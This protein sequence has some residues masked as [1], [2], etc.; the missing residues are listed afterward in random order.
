MDPIT[1]IALS[2][3]TAAGV[4]LQS[5]AS[6]IANMNDQPPPPGSG[7]PGP[8]PYVP[9][10]VVM[11]SIGSGVRADVRPVQPG[12][13]LTYAPGPYADKSALV[14]APNVDLV[15][16]AIEPLLAL[17]LFRASIRVLQTADRM[18]QTLVDLKT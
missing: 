5:A 1:S 16:N 9:T 2:G 18:Q 17:D 15:A 10:Q 11:V 14:A 6:N 12:S 13:A 4:R 3:M 7:A 8:A